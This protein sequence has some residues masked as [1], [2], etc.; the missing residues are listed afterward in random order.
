MGP[1]GQAFRPHV[2]GHWM[3]GCPRRWWPQGISSLPLRLRL[4]ARPAPS[5]PWWGI[6][7]SPQLQP[8]D[9]S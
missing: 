9:V 2:V 8:V 5:L 7:V 3:Q 4:P 1:R 6:F